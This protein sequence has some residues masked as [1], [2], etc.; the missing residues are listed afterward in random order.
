M[1][2]DCLRARL[3]ASLSDMMPNELGNRHS[4]Y[5]R[6]RTRDGESRKTWKLHRDT[7]I[8]QK[9]ES[10]GLEKRPQRQFQPGTRPIDKREA[11]GSCE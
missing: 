9:S 8:G 5:N 3:E 6:K 2:N 7:G 11:G 10:D 1:V 4:K